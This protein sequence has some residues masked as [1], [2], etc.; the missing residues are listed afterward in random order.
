MLFFAVA[1][2]SVCCARFGVRQTHQKS[3]LDIS[4][5]TKKACLLLVCT[6]C[7][8]D[9]AADASAHANA[10]DRNSHC[11]QKCTPLLP[12]MHTAAAEM[13]TSV[14]DRNAHAEAGGNA[15]ADRNAHQNTPKWKSNFAKQFLANTKSVRGFLA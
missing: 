9:A 1:L 2:L 8:A 11:W 10:A 4:R 12:E 3:P 14:V 6:D 15:A 7:S 13:H 5:Y